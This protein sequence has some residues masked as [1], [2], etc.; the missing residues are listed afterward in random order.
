[1]LISYC[2]VILRSGIIHFLIEYKRKVT[3]LMTSI[4]EVFSPLAKKILGEPLMVHYDS[5]EVHG[6]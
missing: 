2:P 1:M 4:A 5:I 6:A 3:W